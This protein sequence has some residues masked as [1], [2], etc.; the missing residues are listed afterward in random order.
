MDREELEQITE[1]QLHD[2]A[3]YEAEAAA[4][5]AAAEMGRHGG[6]GDEVEEGDTDE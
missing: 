2:L 1:Y 3:Y 5:Q 6:D 4:L